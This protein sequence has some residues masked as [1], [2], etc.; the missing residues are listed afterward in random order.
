MKERIHELY[1]TFGKE[2]KS[3]WQSPLCFSTWTELALATFDW[4]ASKQKEDLISRVPGKSYFRFWDDAK[5]TRGVNKGLWIDDRKQFEDLVKSISSIRTVALDGELLNRCLYT[6]SVSFSCAQDVF[7]DSRKMPGTY[8]EYLIRFVLSCFFEVAAQTSLTI[9]STEDGEKDTLAVDLTFD[10]G[11]KRPKFIVPAKTSTRERIIQVWAHQRII[12][13]VF[14]MGRY[15]G[16]PIFLGET[17]TDN[18]K[19][20]VVEI[21]TPFQLKLQNW[22]IARMWQVAY[23]DVPQKYADLRGEEDDFTICT[24]GELLGNSGRLRL[25]IDAIKEEDASAT[26]PLESHQDPT[27]L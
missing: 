12:D 4:C 18:S 11:L 24:L 16:F 7:G 8:F 1:N 10:L 17:K 19:G 23:L 27:E 2:V 15:R 21:C 9:R 14:G 25:L 26:I 22:Y 6:A 13:G 3:D 20:E 5:S